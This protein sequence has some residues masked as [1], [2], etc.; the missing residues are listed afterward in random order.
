MFSKETEIQV[1]YVETDAMAVVH[2]ASYIVWFEI[3]RLD[4]MESIGHRYA[5]IE[6][7][8]FFFPIL[9]VQAKYKKPLRYGEK[10]IV[11]TFLKEFDGL[12]VTLKYEVYHENGELC[13]EGAS[14][15]VLINKDSFRPISLR[16]YLPEFH[17]TL[18]SLLV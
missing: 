9:D 14:T 11:K 6:R 16:K 5:D 12:R 7:D 2:H 8:G 1:R 17:K 3:G 18:N 10:G 13:V 4:F 15:H